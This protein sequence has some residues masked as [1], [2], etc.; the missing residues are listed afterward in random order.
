M[1]CKMALE[2]PNCEAHLVAGGHFVAVEIA[3]QIIARMKQS[4][5]EH[6]E[7]TGN[8]RGQIA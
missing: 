6:D 3:G 5:D 2:L 4:L 1:A 7:L 8:T